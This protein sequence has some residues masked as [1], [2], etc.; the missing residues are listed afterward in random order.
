MDLIKLLIDIKKHRNKNI[1]SR[2]YIGVYMVLDRIFNNLN[3]FKTPHLEGVKY[4]I[5]EN[6]IM[7]SLSNVNSQRIEYGY[8]L[9]K[10][11]DN[12][13]NINI[14]YFIEERLI[15]YFKNINI[16]FISKEYNVS[17][18]GWFEE[19]KRKKL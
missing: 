10:K 15:K 8:N 2:N 18:Y 19:Y 4:Y 11:F 17:G 1:I 12:F 14:D 16:G 9:Y 13:D 5:Y 6:E 3:I 7:F